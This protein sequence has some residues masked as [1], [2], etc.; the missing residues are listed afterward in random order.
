M[1]NKNLDYILEKHADA[2]A[3]MLESLQI[4]LAYLARKLIKRKKKEAEEK[5]KAALKAKK[6]AA[7]KKELERMRKIHEDRKAKK[8]LVRGVIKEALDLFFTKE[9]QRRD[10]I[11]AKATKKGAKKSSV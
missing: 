1:T 9:E 11:V 3:Y 6:K 2:K 4:T 8:R 5:K 7:K 10:E